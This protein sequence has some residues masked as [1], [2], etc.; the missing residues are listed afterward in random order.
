MTGPAGAHSG[1]GS[2]R[3]PV[4]AGD[5]TAVWTSPTYDLS[6]LSTWKGDVYV[7]TG[8]AEAAVATPGYFLVSTIATVA[9][10]WN[11]TDYGGLAYDVY[12]FATGQQVATQTIAAFLTEHPDETAANFGVVATNCSGTSATTAYLDDYTIAVGGNGTTYDFEPGTPVGLTVSAPTRITAGHVAVVQSKVTSNGAAVRNVVVQ[13]IAGTPGTGRLVGTY[14]SDSTGIVSAPVRPVATTTYYWQFAGNAT[15]DPKRSATRTVQVATKLTLSASTTTMK[16]GR[17]LVLTA[18]AYP[19][20]AGTVVT[21]WRKTSGGRTKLGTGTLG[22]TGTLLFAKVL[23]SKGTYKLFA[24]IPAVG[25][26]VGSTSG[27]VTVTV[28]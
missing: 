6:T 23:R 17:P 11:P 25:G 22:S 7:G 24:T 26:D 20:H 28:R 19:H 8:G 3:M 14:T 21:F 4:S 2:L 5:L 10:S 1:V 18:K 13:L 27:I 9:G 12:S 15:Y 16:A